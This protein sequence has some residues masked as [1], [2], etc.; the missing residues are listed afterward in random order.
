MRIGASLGLVVL[1]LAIWVFYLEPASLKNESYRLSV[2]DWPKDC[3][4]FRV[5]LLS[6]L[7]VGSPFNG[8]DKLEKI[9]AL[10]NAA[11]PDLV[12]LAGD[13]V[14]H[15]VVGGTFV[16]PKE[17]A[18]RLSQL[19][20]RL[21][22]F[23]VLGNHDRW[24]GGLKVRGAL[25]DQRIPVLE[26]SATEVSSG[27]CRFWLAGISDFWEGSHDIKKALSRVPDGETVLAFTHNPDVFPQ[28]PN[29]VTLTLAGHTHGG[30]VYFPII[31]RLVVP[32][33][34]GQRYA[35]G[36]IVENDRHLFVTSGLGTSIL[37]VRFLVPPEISVIELYPEE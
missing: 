25:E 27:K 14:I 23:A 10:T 6:D 24:H 5:A 16:E 29:R 22:T 20:P 15:G 18:K 36:H 32:S 12:L 21:G 34:Y 11:R 7:H 35:V 4:G 2:P 30:Q 28:I 26:D 3:T 19:K 8:V 33:N 37:P 17:I 31:G 9:V 1:S 13:F